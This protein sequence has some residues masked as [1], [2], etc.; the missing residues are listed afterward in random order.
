MPLDP[1]HRGLAFVLLAALLWASSAV[2]GKSLFAFGV[3]PAALVQARCTLG[4]VALGLYLA[5]F[6]RRD[7]AIARRDLPA[8][9]LLGAAMA[10]VQS[11]Y[12]RAV[13]AIPVAAAI[14]L[15]Y[16]SAFL[17]LCFSAAFL[18]ERLTRA[19]IAALALAAVG[20]FLVAGGYDIGL[21]AMSRAG[22]AWGLGAAVLFATYTLLG[23]RLMR[24]RGPLAVLFFAL[25]FAAIPVNLVGPPLDFI[26]GLHSVDL[27]WRI[28][29][30]ALLG[31]VAP[32]G[33]YFGGVR[34]LGASK[35]SIAAM[36]E[37]V[38]SAGFA[39]AF[40]G[41]ALEW[42]QTAGAVGV[43]A[44]VVVLER[45]REREGISR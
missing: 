4:A 33:L 31:T 15:Q 2:V 24:R 5:L 29:W 25:A 20:C 41:E 39:F 10:G 40:L 12:F 22:V 27:G 30:V 37:P 19:K 26:A 7:L 14:L 1:R 42:P 18:G 28:V 36:A 3:T 11:C 32:F 9:A 43:I 21:A 35:A 13:A 16:S 34:L 45:F 6:G 38:F 8:L 17:V 44:A 23:A